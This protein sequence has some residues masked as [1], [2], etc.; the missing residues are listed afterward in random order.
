[1]VVHFPQ[2]PV[3]HPI[4]KSMENVRLPR[5]NKSE[6]DI[7]EMLN[8]RR[9]TVKRNPQT[10]SLDRSNAFLQ[11]PLSTGSISYS[12]QSSFDDSM[13][14][15]SVS[16]ELDSEQE[17]VSN[18]LSIKSTSSYHIYKYSRRE[19]K[20]FYASV[21]RARLKKQYSLVKRPSNHSARFNHKNCSIRLPTQITYRQRLNTNSNNSYPLI[22]D[23]NF[24]SLVQISA[25]NR[26]DKYL[27]NMKI[28]FHL[29]H[30]VASQEFQII[31]NSNDQQHHVS[32]TAFS[33][34]NLLRRAMADFSLSL[35]KNFK[36]N[37]FQTFQLNEQQMC[38]PTKQQRIEPI[39][40]D[41]DGDSQQQPESRTNPILLPKPPPPATTTTVRNPSVTENDSLQFNSTS[42]DRQQPIDRTNTEPF[43]VAFAPVIERQKSNHRSSSPILLKKQ[44]LEPIQ[45]EESISTFDPV[46]IRI[47][48]DMNGNDRTKLTP[49]RKKPSNSS[50]KLDE[51]SPSKRP[52]RMSTRKSS[53]KTEILSEPVPPY[54]SIPV[55]LT[56]SEIT[57]QW[58][59]R[60]A[61]YRCHACSH[62][63]FFVVLSR[64][65][66]NL[67]ISSKH[68][69]MEENFK[70][71]LSTFLNNKGRS[72]KIFQH[73]LKWQKPWSDKEVEQI[74]KLSNK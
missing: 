28:Y 50:S 8:L 74:F 55:Q 46:R 59:T 54:Q 2:C 37:Y 69:N 65:C 63:E 3:K 68:G 34:F 42:I 27:S 49:S 39:H 23:P 51:N 36:R 62:E 29:L 48:N 52:S 26:F 30:S 20:N 47:I 22:F 41:D 4:K 44:K 66:M 57:R 7:L 16:N 13:C 6:H 40:L 38:V 25:N 24:Q 72:I 15:H 11:I 43:A 10:P 9:T 61:F 21:K 73:Y 33:F 5:L 1:M 32:Y 19:K 58:L 12:K 14:H 35:Q 60:N 45:S 31:V 17:Q 64:E 56:S 18:N 53:I 67:H 70:Q 71:R